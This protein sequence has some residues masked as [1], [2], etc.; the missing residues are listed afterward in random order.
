MIRLITL[1]TFLTVVSKL[2]AHADDRCASI[3]SEARWIQLDRV[4][5]GDTI[6]LMDRTRVCL[7]GRVAPERDQRYGPIS[8]AALEYMVARNVYLVE[9]DKDRYGRL[10]GQLYHSKD[11]YDI[12][13]SIVCAGHAWWYERYAL[14]SQI[15]N[16]YQVGAQQASGGIWEEEDPM[17]PWEWRRK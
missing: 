12:N 10:V 3:P 7:H 9:V 8:T 5:D 11:G 4:A 13:A 1:M 6:V 16:D 17:P 15:L 2:S 14:E